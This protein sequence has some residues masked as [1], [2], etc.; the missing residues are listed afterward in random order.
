M[1]LLVTEVRDLCKE[2]GRQSKRMDHMVYRV[3]VFLEYSMGFN[4]LLARMFVN[5]GFK[6][7]E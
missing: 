2:L 5:D 3:D 7:S 4:L 6:A 1:D